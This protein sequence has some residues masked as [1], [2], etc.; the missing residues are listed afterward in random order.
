MIPISEVGK[1]RHRE[2][3]SLAQGHTARKWQSLDLNLGVLGPQS[4]PWLFLHTLFKRAP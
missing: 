2:D 4:P 3:K 1:L